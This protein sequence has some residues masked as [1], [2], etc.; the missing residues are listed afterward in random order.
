MTTASDLFG[1]EKALIGMIHVQALPGTPGGKLPVADI[2]ETA[3]EEAKLLAEAGFDAIIIENMH[4]VPYLR[5]EVGPEIVAAM[6][7]VGGAVREAAGGLPLGV[8]ILAGANRAALAVAQAVGAQF[9]RAEGFVF[10]S[11]ADEGLLEEADAGPLLRYRRAIGAEDVKILADIK[12]KHSAH[13]ITADVDLAATARA[14]EFF[15]ADGLIIT[16]LATA[17]PTAL[18][19]VRQI[20]KEADV[21]VF[22][23]SGVT[24]DTVRGLLEHADGLIVGSWYKKDGL[25]SNPPDAQRASELVAAFRAARD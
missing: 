19:D 14:A 16:G 7:A 8:Q 18:Q 23:G 22:V 21:P 13:A 1:R 4:D 11:V 3:A 25:W 17:E 6:S 9:I 15:G 24:P 5:R 12:K 2:A 10:A 20:G